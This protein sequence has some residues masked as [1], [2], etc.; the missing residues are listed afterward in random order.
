M[1]QVPL[2][3]W[4]MAVIVIFGLSF[5]RLKGLQGPLAS[6]NSMAHVIYRAS[7]VR[8]YSNLLSMAVVT[9]EIGDY[10]ANLKEELGILSTEYS[11]LLYGGQIKVMVGSIVERAA[12][13]YRYLGNT[14][15]LDAW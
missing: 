5:Q 6:L 8:M 3:L 9:S 4:V 13:Q 10:R 11:T 7:R 15:Q 14:C 2:I 1:L 12:L